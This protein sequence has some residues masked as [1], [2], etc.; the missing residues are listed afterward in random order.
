MKWK[1][2]K[3]SENE[4]KQQVIYKRPQVE[5]HYKTHSS[6][7]AITYNIKHDLLYKGHW[8][9]AGDRYSHINFHHLGLLL[10]YREAPVIDFLRVCVNP[11]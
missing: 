1:Y 4:I 5:G 7:Y 6:W 10:V 11:I 3:K 8:Y 9:S 2:T